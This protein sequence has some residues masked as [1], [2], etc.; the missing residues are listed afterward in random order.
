MKVKKE[1][2]RLVKPCYH[3]IPPPTTLVVPLSVFDTV[4]FDIHVAVI[5]VYRS[6]VP[7]N[8][9]VEKGLSMALSEYREWAGRLGSDANGRPAILLNDRGVRFIEASVDCALEKVMPLWPSPAMLS[10]HPSVKGPDELVQVQLTRFA[11][12]SLVMGFTTHHMVADGHAT[13]NFMVAWGKA[14]RGLPMD[15]LPLHGRSEFFV[16]RNPPKVEFEHRGVEFQ[17]EKPLLPI[18][19]KVGEGEEDKGVVALE[20]VEDVIVHRAHFSVDFLTKLKATVATG[21][22]GGKASG[23]TGRPH[24]TFQCLLAHLWRVTT[25]ARELEPQ[26]TTQVRIA[27]NGRSRLRPPVPEQFFGN[28]VLW[29]FPRARV[30]DLLAQPLAY[31]TKLIRDAVARVDD[32][33][34]RSFVDYASSGS[35]EAEG[36]EST[37]ETTDLVLSPN[38][39]VDSWLGFP[40]YELDFGG[41]GPFLFMP[42]YLPVEGAVVLLRSFIGDG[43]IDAYV[44]LFRR[45]LPTFK[46]LCY[47]ALDA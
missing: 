4:N 19:A 39:E 22:I 10:L 6:P 9:K 27:V 12:G 1:S 5:Y 15:P 47:A 43:S 37:A 17:M 32:G 38:L 31:A 3:G 35:V 34:F 36:L 14:T 44:P 41:G 23:S 20:D 28:L 45:N 13:S 42:G 33:Y 24:S 21:N 30:R 46:T 25:R 26:E 2:S 16:P 18:G 8:S 29:A 40:F 7:P 11:C